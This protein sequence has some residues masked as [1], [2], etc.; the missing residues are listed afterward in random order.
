MSSPPD[1]DVPYSSPKSPTDRAP[2]FTSP[3][4]SSELVISTDLGDSTRSIRTPVPVHPAS[5]AASPRS[6][7]APTTSMAAHTTAVLDAVSRPVEEDLPPV[8]PVREVTKPQLFCLLL[9]SPLLFLVAVLWFIVAS[10]CI[11]SGYCAAQPRSERSRPQPPLSA[12]EESAQLSSYRRN[13]RGLWMF[14][15]AWL[16]PSGVP[17]RAV[18]FIVHG[19]AEHISRPGWEELA[20]RMAAEGYAVHGMDAQGHGRS[21]GLRGYVERWDDLVD[22]ELDFI[23]SFNRAYPADMPRVLF[24]HSLGGLLA[25]HVAL[26]YRAE[27]S[28]ADAWAFSMLILSAPAAQADPKV[29]TP[30]NKFLARVGSVLAPKQRVDTLDPGVLSRNQK[31]VEVF[32]NDPLVDHDGLRAR[33]AREILRGQNVVRGVG[34]KTPLS[35][36]AM[37]VMC[38]HGTADVVVPVSASRFV[39]EHVGSG[40]KRLCLYERAYHELFEDRD[41]DMFFNDILHFI[42]DQLPRANK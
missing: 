29:A 17:V 9:L 19:L 5:A 6:P 37:P 11:L 25:L 18:V 38:L 10:P 39:H 15:R 4:S 32:R 12:D 41:R 35:S 33:F 21:A 26:R 42:R 2:P 34:D 30:L 13:P 31:A 22:D 14:T 27:H 7:H 3:M 8:P 20:R 23:R 16:P 36:L 24:G 1:P 40:T 28:P